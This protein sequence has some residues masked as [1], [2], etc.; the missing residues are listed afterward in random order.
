[1]YALEEWQNSIQLV[2]EITA[3][4]CQ[5]KIFQRSG[6]PEELIEKS[7][8]KLGAR[9]EQ[10]LQNQLAEKLLPQARIA[11]RMKEARLAA[12]DATLLEALINSVGN[13]EQLSA[14]GGGWMESG[15]VI[16]DPAVKEHWDSFIEALG[17]CNATDALG[18]LSQLLSDVKWD[19]VDRKLPP[20][21]PPYRI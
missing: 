2:E 5:I 19:L 1:M 14:G 4:E 7:R 15:D 18:A 8:T 10:L 12:M 9:Y 11:I 3:I 6:A 20:A 16:T 17:R 13:E 21:A